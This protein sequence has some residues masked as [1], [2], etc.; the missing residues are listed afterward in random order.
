MKKLVEFSW[1]SGVK[2]KLDSTVYNIG[3]ETSHEIEMSDID[4]NIYIYTYNPAGVALKLHSN[5]LIK[6]LHNFYLNKQRE[7]ELTKQAHLK[8]IYETGA[9]ITHDIKNLLQSLQAITSIV[10]HD[11]DNSNITV[12][13]KVLKKQLPNLTQRL[14]LALDKLQTPQNQDTEEIYLKDW[15]NDLQKRNAH[16]KILFQAVIHN[17]PTIPVDLFDSVVD[18]LLENIQSKQMNEPEIEITITL[19]CNEDVTSVTVCD[20]GSIIPDEICRDLLSNVIASDN[21]L[22]I[23]L[24]QASK[25]AE[26]FAY[27]LSLINNQKGRVCFELRSNQDREKS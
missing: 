5:L 18:N 3:I 26:I 17:D 24:Y 8:A 11:S 2:C 6:L 13:Q 19:A 16:N 23:G 25:H 9:R 10:T 12:T 4:F 27:K 15:W 14:Q 20:S 7:K 21:G 22:G 1:I